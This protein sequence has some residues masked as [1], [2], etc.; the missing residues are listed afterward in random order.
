MSHDHPQRADAAP[1]SWW[2]D[3]ADTIRQRPALRAALAV[4]LALFLLAVYAPLLASDLPLLA[5]EHSQWSS[6][7]LNNLFNKT[8]YDGPLDPTFN[9][10]I[11][12]LPLYGLA[13]WLLLR[14]IPHLSR[15]AGALFVLAASWLALDPAA[16]YLNPP[17]SPR[18]SGLHDLLGAYQAP[19]PKGVHDRSWQWHLPAPI[20]FS[21]RTTTAHP[22]S[23]PTWQGRPLLHSILWQGSTD[24]PPRLHLAPSLPRWRHPLGT[25]N[26]GRD[27]TARLCY[28]A[29]AAITVGLAAAAIAVGLGTLLGL[30]AGW[31]GGWVDLLIS[32]L[33]E[34]MVC[35]PSLILIL[36]LTALLDAPSLFHLI[37]VIGLTR[38]TAPARL[39]RGEALRL[40][41]EVYITAALALGLRPREVLFRHLLP[42]AIGAL[43][44]ATTFAIANAIL[45]ESTV[46]LLGMGD[47]TVPTWGKMLN[48]GRVFHNT[49]M[50]LL[51]GLALFVTLLAINLLGEGLRDAFDPRQQRQRP[52]PS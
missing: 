34:V 3:L 13:R 37:A 32:R 9:L 10:L 5:R 33:I 30:L 25:D 17:D 47:A 7:W 26:L 2:Q 49:A 51:P 16:N 11:L 38:W 46:A 50:M 21:F 28:G 35:F 6:P 14:R 31:V 27:L 4:L 20:A 45:V 12:A 48:D 43:A 52:P 40:R 15:W 36:A 29:R 39:M 41:Q 18:E 8:Y 24:A 44:V 1:P 23:A 19:Y 22:H 42:N